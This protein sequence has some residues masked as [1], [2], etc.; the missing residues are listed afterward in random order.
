MKIIAIATLVGDNRQVLAP[1]EELDLADD[2]A[3]SLVERGLAALPK[4]ADRRSG[5]SAAKPA[6]KPQESAAGA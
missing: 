4:E 1:G 3:L 5:K 2:Q 6:A